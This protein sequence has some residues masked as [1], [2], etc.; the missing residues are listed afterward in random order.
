[1]RCVLL[2]G[3]FTAACVL[4][5]VPAASATTITQLTSASQL[6][7]GDTVLNPETAAHP[8]GSVTSGPSISYNTSGGSVT[9]SRGSGHFEV[10]QAGYTYGDTAFANGTGLIGAGGFQGAGD[11]GPITLSFG[12]ATNQF[13]LNIEEF[14]GGPYQVDFTAFDSAGNALGTFAAS[15]DDPFNSATGSLSFEGLSVSGDSISKVVFSDTAAGGSNNLVFGNVEF[16]DPQASSVTPEPNS[17]VLLG[18]G[19]L[20]VARAIR[21]R[22][23]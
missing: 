9:L 8:V 16:G 22:M 21:R 11:G 13:G 1:M 10:D 2:S 4:T 14:N 17:M 15:G 20:I 6:G 3:L 12:T 23:A 19:L 18:T 7:A 5:V